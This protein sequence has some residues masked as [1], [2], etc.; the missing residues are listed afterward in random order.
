MA[1]SDEPDPAQLADDDDAGVVG[2]QEESEQ[3][4]DSQEN[5][6]DDDEEEDG[7]EAKAQD[8][9][10]SESLSEDS[11]SSSDDDD[12]DDDSSNQEEEQKVVIG[13]DGHALSAYEIQRLERIRRNKE[14]LV[15]LG[16]EKNK[17]AMA[18]AKKKK[19]KSAPARKK[20]PDIKRRSSIS[21]ASKEKVV[22]YSERSDKDKKEPADTNKPQEPWTRKKESRGARMERF[23]HDEFRRIGKEQKVHLK[24]AQANVRKADV[25]LRIAKQRVERFEKKQR[26]Q[27]E[28]L[29]SAERSRKEQ[30]SLGGLTARQMLQEIDTRSEEIR[31]ALQEF[32]QKFGVS[33]WCRIV[34]CLLQR[35]F[36]IILTLCFPQSPS[37]QEDGNM[38][39]WA[40]QQE[41]K[42]KKMELIDAMDRFPRAL[43]VRIKS[44]CA[45]LCSPFRVSLTHHC[46]C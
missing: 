11:A 2:R 3:D 44:G 23:I 9:Q 40:K 1:D 16:L 13:E 41:E 34:C 4:Q 38:A 15:S 31:M 7:G 19:K 36:Y 14:Y 25:E 27:L 24:R 45:F 43:K 35:I 20:Q 22:T 42:R 29:Q 10:D 39:E 12:D 26:R 33:F 46:C 30:Q 28:Y 18:A 37:S 21:R 32:D 17:E 5:D 8:E 6:K